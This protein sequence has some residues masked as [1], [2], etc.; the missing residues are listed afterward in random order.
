[1]RRPRKFAAAL[2]AAPLLAL[3]ITAAGGQTTETAAPEVDRIWADEGLR[4]AA[5]ARGEAVYAAHCASCHGADLKGAPGVPAPDLTDDYWLFGGEDMDTFQVRP[6]DVETI[7]R[8]GLRTGQ[9]GERLASPMPGWADIAARSPGLGPSEL[10]DVTDYVLHLAGQPADAEAARRGRQLFNGRATCF[11][12]H[13]SDAKGD[14]SI[15]AP[16]LTRPAIWLHGTDRAAIRATIVQGRAN[17]MPAYADQLDDA[18]IRDV[19][20]FVHA[21]AAAY[22]F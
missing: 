11:D 22:D 1:M 18:A 13:A 20:L 4:A 14:S 10:D 19:S 7:V 6:S 9:A 3:A 12:C 16:D 17:T 2:L 5:I 21:R 15:G 8:H